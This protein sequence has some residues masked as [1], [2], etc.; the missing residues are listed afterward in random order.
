MAI[1]RLYYSDAYGVFKIDL[2]DLVGESQDA[3][4]NMLSYPTIP[5]N[6][7][8]S[9]SG[10]YIDSKNI[11]LLSFGQQT[12]DG[13][14]LAVVTD[15][16][17]INYYRD[18]YN[19]GRAVMNDDGTLYVVN[20]DDNQVEVFYGADSRP[21]AGRA[22]DFIYSATSTPPLFNNAG[23]PGDLLT[24]HIENNRSSALDGGTRLFVGQSIGMTIIDT[25]DEESP[26]GY[27][28]GT[29]S[30]GTSISLGIVGS[31]ADYESIGGTIPHVVDI[32]VDTNSNII[33]VVTNNNGVGGISQISTNN[34]LIIFMD[35]DSGFVPSDDIRK[36]SENE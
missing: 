5:T 11:L 24:L 19:C 29:D 30:S 21:G 20:D 32:E 16:T 36:V 14:G 34:R 6:E 18:G 28:A 22:P 9:I 10:N 3:V 15:E 2:I 12:T 4:T 8:I 1:N 31:G 7:V 17:S 23:D 13:Y 26:D 33:F 25:H 35:K 27:A